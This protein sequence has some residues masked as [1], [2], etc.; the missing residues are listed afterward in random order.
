MITHIDDDGYLWFSGIGGWDDQVLV[1]QRIRVM[2]THETVVGVIGKKPIH[3]MDPEDR[4]K[5]SK[6]KTLWIDIGAA[7]AEDAPKES[8]DRGSGC[9]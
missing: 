7:N 6:M 2:G 9:C 3:Q 1:G 4:G 5:V 8:R